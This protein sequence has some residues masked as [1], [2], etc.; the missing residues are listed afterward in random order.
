MIDW[1]KFWIQEA[2]IIRGILANPEINFIGNYNRNTGEIFEFPLKAHYREWELEIKSQTWLEVSGSL[3]KFWNKGTNGN[4]FCYHFLFSSI[5]QLSNLL[6]VNPFLLT[7]H[8]IEFGVN[9]RPNTNS[10]RILK[11][12]I[13]F[14]NVESIKKIRPG[15]Y[16]IEF[17][18]DKY[19]LKLY[20]KG[21]QAKTLW[22]MDIGNVMRIEIKAVNATFF[23]DTGLKTLADLLNPK[24][25]LLLGKK[26]HK[27][28]SSIVFNDHTIN[29][30][31]M[32]R[33]DQ[34]N[35]LLNSNPKEWST[36]KG[37]MNSTAAYNQNK[38]K[39][40]VKKYG[41]M[42]YQDVLSILVSDKLNELI[43][44]SP[45][46]AQSVSVFLR[47]CETCGISY[48]IYREKL[49]NAA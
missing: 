15:T 47:H 48:L 21:L 8:N 45:D 23:K 31:V 11:D 4:D 34:K 29:Y 22:K 33:P 12:V 35:Y 3:H 26:I 42:N 37:R 10:I 9:I 27:L 2:F 7:V 39:S 5:V 13:C 25:L 28:F 43:K 36:K 38:F 49:P 18:M 17:E 46:T 6:H 40:I 32:T 19:Y 16:F 44:V 20:D 41:T 1:C 24:V 30:K 14:K